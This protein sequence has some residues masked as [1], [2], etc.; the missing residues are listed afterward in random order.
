MLASYDG[1]H[2]DELSSPIG[3]LRIPLLSTNFSTNFMCGVGKTV[4]RVVSPK[5]FIKPET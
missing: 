4:L 5:M 2:I 1:R 3:G